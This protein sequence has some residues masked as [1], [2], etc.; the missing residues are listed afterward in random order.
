VIVA[1]VR[2]TETEDVLVPEIWQYFP[3]PVHRIRCLD[4]RETFWDLNLDL[5]SFVALGNRM[6]LFGSEEGHDDEADLQDDALPTDRALPRWDTAIVV[7]ARHLV[8]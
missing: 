1:W 5:Q 8:E 7:S 6:L 3:P 2:H 4:L